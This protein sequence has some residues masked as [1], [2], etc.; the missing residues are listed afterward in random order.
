VARFQGALKKESPDLPGNRV[1]QV[2]GK[3]P[4]RP[5][6]EDTRHIKVR[7]RSTFF[8]LIVLQVSNFQVS[9]HRRG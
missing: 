4:T 8:A 9:K 6:L 1:E 3:N 2:L 5:S 7:L